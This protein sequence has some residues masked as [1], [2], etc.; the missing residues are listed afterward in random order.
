MKEVINYIKPRIVKIVCSDIDSKGTGFIISSDGYIATNFHVIAKLV[1]NG[2]NV[3]PSYSSNIIIYTNDGN[4]F[5][6]EIVNNKQSPEHIL[7]DYA[8]LK[9]VPKKELTFFELGDSSLAEEGET[10]YFGGFPLTQNALTSHTGLVSCIREAPTNLGLQTQKVIDI[11]ATVVGGNS[12]GPL[13]IKNKE[14]FTVVGMISQQ[15]A[16]IT[17]AFSQLE[18]FLSVQMTNPNSGSVFIGGVNPN[19][20]LFEMIKV[21]KSNLSTGIGTAISIDYLKKEFDSILKK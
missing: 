5:K 1:K 13:I 15:V 18:N 17:E 16:I 4:N 19:L 3:Q 2:Q 10:I 9:I 6:A 14:K 7:H 12:G 8:I 20:A 21:I 11:D